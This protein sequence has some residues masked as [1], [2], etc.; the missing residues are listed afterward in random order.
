MSWTHLSDTNPKARKDHFC[1]LCERIILKGTVHVARRG[2]GDGG[3]CTIRMHIACEIVSRGF[4]ID[5]WEN[6]DPSEFRKDMED[7]EKV[8]K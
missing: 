7:R 8:L 6:L 2:I 1:E 3:P 5:E 4:D